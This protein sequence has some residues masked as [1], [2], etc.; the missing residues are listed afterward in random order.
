MV[1]FLLNLNNSKKECENISNLIIIVTMTNDV[2]VIL[3][4]MMMM[5]VDDGVLAMM[6]MIT[7]KCGYFSS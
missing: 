2:I 4:E 3:M 1:H 7:I 5:F 6:I